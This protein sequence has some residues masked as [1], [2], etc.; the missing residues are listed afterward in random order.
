MGASSTNF[1]LTPE[2]RN[3]LSIQRFLTLKQIIF[4]ELHCALPGVVL[5]FNPGPPATVDVQLAVNR[6]KQ[7]S[8]IGQPL[9]PQTEY[10]PFPI[11]QGVPIQI[12]GGGGW[13]FTLP[14]KAGDECEI[15]FNDMAI[16]TWFQS[17][18]PIQA[19][20]GAASA[21]PVS[22]RNHDLSDAIALFG[23]RSTPRAIQNYS[24]TE[25]E[26]RSDDGT[27]VIGMSLDQVTI[28]APN[29]V[30]NAT[31]KASISGPAVGIGDAAS[32]TSFSTGIDG[33]LFMGHQHVGVATGF[34]VSGPVWPS[35]PP[36][37]EPS[38]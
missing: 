31:A 23:L 24:I 19:N 38:T 5:A 1:G 13:S 33:R 37:P 36:G 2:Q 4:Q 28:T 15:L 32:P 8:A 16:D 27:V 34:G 12:Y 10:A 25:A 3:A 22:V 20:G 9:A 17:G 29:V 18:A 30:V 11:L 35:S 21:N 6:R 7:T 26:L 14:I